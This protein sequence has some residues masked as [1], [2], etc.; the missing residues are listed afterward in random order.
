MEEKYEMVKSAK[1]L[2]FT[3]EQIRALTNLSEE[4]INKILIE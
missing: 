3:M 1:S 2:G 4:E